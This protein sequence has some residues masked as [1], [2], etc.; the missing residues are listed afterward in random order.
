MNPD[1]VSLPLRDIHMPDTVSW[2]P[3]AIGWWILLGLLV[4]IVAITYIYKY[5]KKRKQFSKV[6]LQEFNSVA[7]QFKTQADSQK[8]IEDLSMLLRRITISAFPD[9]HV[10]GMTGG[11]W[12]KFLDEVASQSSP[13]Q[14]PTKFDSPLGQCLI[15]GPYQKHVSLGQ[16]EI[17]QLLALCQ[18]WIQTVAR[19]AHPQPAAGE[20]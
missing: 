12:L 6:A 16:Q 10:A 11:A 8:L 4:A 17:Q 18:Q 20:H 13:Q 7:E 5:L 9:K 1:I 19:Q 14:M 15:T 2:W 3:L